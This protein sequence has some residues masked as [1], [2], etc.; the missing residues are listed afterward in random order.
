MLIE[1]DIE[2]S[3]REAALPGHARFGRDNSV[4]REI[5]KDATTLAVWTRPVPERIAAALAGLELSIF[6][7]LRFTAPADIVT[8]ELGRMLAA[9]KLPIEVYW[10]IALDAGELAGLY[11][12]TMALVLVDIRLEHIPGEGCRKFHADY[13]TTRLL[14]TYC[15]PGTQWL[16]LQAGRRQLGGE[17]ADPAGI[18]QLEAGDVAL[19][20]GRESANDR[21]LVHRSPP[22]GDG[23]PGRLLLVINPGQVI[24]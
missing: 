11:A 20:K 12:S 3:G 7:A 10:P 1:S 24:E 19:L 5:R 15:G 23:G 16:D 13:V 2:R 6:G 14:T 8:Y 17:P 4:L 22:V 9:R 18:R 21:A